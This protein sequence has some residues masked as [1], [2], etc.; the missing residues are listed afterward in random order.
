MHPPGLRADLRRG[1]L[2]LF[3]FG[4]G[5]FLALVAHDNKKKD[6]MEWA[7]FNRGTLLRHQLCATGTTIAPFASFPL[8][9]L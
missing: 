5:G 2:A 9:L 7:S 6:L 8:R 4:S 1:L 3:A